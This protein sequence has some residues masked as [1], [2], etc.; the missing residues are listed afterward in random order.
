VRE[1]SEYFH[2]A[3]KYMKVTEMQRVIRKFAVLAASLVGLFAVHAPLRPAQTTPITRV[4][5]YETKNIT[6]SSNSEHLVFEDYSYETAVRLTEPGWY[7]YNPVSAQ[8]TQSDTWPLL[9]ALSTAQQAAFN[10][11]LDDHNNPISVNHELAQPHPPTPSPHGREGEK[12]RSF[13]P[14]SI[15]WRGV[16]GEVCK[17]SVIH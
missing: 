15:E 12:T 6:W 4:Y 13:K 16:W 17:E 9:P 5:Q 11:I 3:A 10:P 2:Q 1:W 8:L 14:L 7:Q